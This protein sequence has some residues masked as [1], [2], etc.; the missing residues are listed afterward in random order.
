MKADR[1]PYRS[2]KRPQTRQTSPKY[3][4]LLA[5]SSRL[6]VMGNGSMRPKL[7]CIVSTIGSADDATPYSTSRLGRFGV[8]VANHGGTVVAAL[9]YTSLVLTWVHHANADMGAPYAILSP[10]PYCNLRCAKGGL[11]GYLIK[12]QKDKI[13]RCETS[14][15]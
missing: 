4:L 9:I 11:R 12:F 1:E 14:I 13:K 15:Q 2:S 10:L 7:V 8:M 3:L 5:L 6:H